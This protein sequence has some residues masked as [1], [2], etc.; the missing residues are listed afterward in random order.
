MVNETFSIL[1]GTTLLDFVD[2]TGVYGMLKT[3]LS[4]RMHEYFV[5]MYRI[6][7]PMWFKH[8][9]YPRWRELLTRILNGNNNKQS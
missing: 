7:V 1:K 2:Y 4:P 6:Y 8:I 5:F 3:V 9:F